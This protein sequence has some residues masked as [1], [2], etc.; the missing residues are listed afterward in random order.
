[1]LQQDGKAESILVKCRGSNSIFFLIHVVICNQMYIQN[2][3][4]S[5]TDLLFDPSGRQWRELW[6]K[7]RIRC[8]LQTNLNEALQ[9]IVAATIIIL[10]T[11]LS[12]C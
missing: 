8:Y 10:H 11:L 9:S 7:S 4:L 6:R 5:S 12:A 1:M 3:I 2:R